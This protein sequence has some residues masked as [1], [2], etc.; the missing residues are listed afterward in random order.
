M[1][2]TFTKNARKATPFRAGMQSVG[3]S[4]AILGQ[5]RV[6]TMSDLATRKSTKSR[7]NLARPM[8][9]GAST[10]RF[11]LRRLLGK[12]DKPNCRCAGAPASKLRNPRTLGRGGVK[13]MLATLRGWA[14][15]GIPIMALGMG[16]DRVA[17][18]AGAGG[19]KAG[20]RGFG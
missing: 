7:I 17:D 9:A 15:V 13:E 5:E 20:G 19:G 4:P 16:F 18:R 1:I 3:Q 6:R 11:R 8:L 12:A 14:L 10:G 2:N